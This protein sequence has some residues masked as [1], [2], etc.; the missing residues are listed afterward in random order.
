[1]IEQAK[2]NAMTEVANFDFDGTQAVVK[3]WDEELASR[4]DRGGTQVNASSL[5]PVFT[6][7][8]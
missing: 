3:A 7:P 2:K 8:C 1:L 4:E 5:P 6:T